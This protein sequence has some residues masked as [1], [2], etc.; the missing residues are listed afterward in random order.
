MGGQTG[1]V[2]GTGGQVFSILKSEDANK[3]EALASDLG[4]EFTDVAPIDVEAP[5]FMTPPSDDDDDEGDDDEEELLDPTDLNK[6]RRYLEDT[7][8]FSLDG[9]DK[10][11]SSPSII[12]V[13]IED[14][15]E[16]PGF[17]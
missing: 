7:V 6:M 2:R 12:D 14:V 17:Q 9:D 5:R 16:Y 11:P 3:M 13:E 10:S 1:S 15:D 8:S 4:F